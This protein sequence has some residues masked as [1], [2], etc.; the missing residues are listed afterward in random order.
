MTI[1]V[2]Q[3]GDTVYSIATQYST[4]PSAI[5]YDNQLIPPY[6]LAIGQAFLIPSG[7]T[8]EY[9]PP[10]VSNGYAYPFISRQ[11]LEQT[12]PFLTSLSVF[13]YGFTMEGNLVPPESDDTWMVN[14]AIKND[15]R[16]ILTLTPL[17]ETGRFNNQ[18]ITSIVNSSDARDSLFNQLISVMSTKGYSGLDIDFE[19]IKAEDRDPF[20]AFVAEAV[21]R[22]RPGRTC[23]LCSSD[24]LRMGLHLW[25]EYGRRPS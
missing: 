14:T 1:Y 23:R 19:Y 21:G 20:T 9:R 8:P 16:S 24:D 13:S 5:I 7:A 18:L 4:A 15:V 3:P 11:V 25:T 2:V 10:V 12:P 6:T 22:L 17:D